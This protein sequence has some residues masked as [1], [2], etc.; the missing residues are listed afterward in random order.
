MALSDPRLNFGV[1]SVTPYNRTT[2]VP[3]GILKVLGNSSLNLTGEQIDLFGGSARF[4]W[5]TGDGTITSEMS[6]AVKELPDF[7]F[8]LFLGKTP[9]VNSAEATG[10]VS[11]ITNKNGTSVVSA[12]VGIASVAATGSDEADLKFGRYTV[13]AT[14]ANTVDLYCMSDVDFARGTDAE[15]E[16]DT[17]SIASA[18]T[19][20]DT[21]GT[22]AVADF[23]LTFTGGSGTVAFTTGDTATFE[24]RP[25]NT[26]STTV[27][28]GGTADTFP[29][30][31]SV[32]MAQ[33]KAD[34]RMFEIDAFKCKSLGM[35]LN[36]QEKAFSEFEIT[37]K[38][39]YDS[40]KN[41]VFDMREVVI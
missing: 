21:G 1:H 35:P 39:L 8:Q 27:R 24:V 36:F 11:T 9:T 32:I 14:G 30:F 40:A 15:F 20:P 37:V 4:A 3:Y 13:V 12:T 33:Q 16:D 22:V 10:N 18:I 19:I 28:V 29:Y 25:I 41:G 26:A 5:D 23:G 38:V 7:L 2:G 6:L 34:G 31:G 17:L